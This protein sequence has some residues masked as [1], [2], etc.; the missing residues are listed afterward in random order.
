MPLFL[1]VKG[2]FQAMARLLFVFNS[3]TR[4]STAK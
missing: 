2:S 3:K 4:L 1:V